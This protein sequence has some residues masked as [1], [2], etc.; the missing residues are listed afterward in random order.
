M[1]TDFDNVTWEN[2]HDDFL[3]ENHR[4]MSSSS[5]E[6]DDNAL[7]GSSATPV[8]SHVGG[9][10]IDVGTAMGDRLECT[11]T[12]P[13]K[14]QDGTKDAFVSYLITTHSDF[15]TFQKPVSS[16]RRR[17]TDFVY[18]YKALV[19]EYMACAV[20]PIPDKQ[21]IEYVRGDRFGSEFTGRRAKSLERFL[22]RITM[23]PHLRRARI[24]TSFLESQ[25]WN[26]TMRSRNQRNSMSSD[27]GA[28]GSGAGGVFDA[29][30]DSVINAFTK[31]HKPD[32]R[33]I[34]VRDATDKLDENL[35]SIEKIL[36]RVV[37]RQSDLETD[38]RELADQFRKLIAM[39]PGIE[40]QVRAFA[41]AIDRTAD[42]LRRMRDASDVDYLGS[43]RDMEAYCGAVK[44]LLKTREQKQLDY[45]QLTEY[46]TKS[47]AERE[48]MR[49]GGT[50]ASVSGGVGG[51]VGGAASYALGITG[52]IRS[53][54]E[55]ARGVDHEQARRE[56]QRKLEMRIE[57]LSNEAHGA[58]ITAEQFN[59]EVLHEVKNFERA[60][61]VEFRGQLLGL[62]DA[63][64]AYYD[65][66]ADVWERYIAEQEARGGKV[67]QV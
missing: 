55:D 35:A 58:K 33:F 64:L 42:N 18:L 62:C 66:V 8:P 3:S 22:S 1:D 28:V 65:G 20:P 17:F 32:Q 38:Q 27:G 50:S 4:P 57:M 45:E 10:E 12:L 67:V 25:D 39:E 52:A 34:D 30:A 44:T 13:I 53:R 23:H 7:A 6:Y 54:I 56:R 37:R 19:K 14:E 60:K 5:Y 47:S 9:G 59:E 61:R 24:L 31:V 46:L 40:D 2:D 16:V 63:N 26:A 11:V 49:A 51:A 36:A 29:F 21:R 48:A 41:T 43:V 15:P